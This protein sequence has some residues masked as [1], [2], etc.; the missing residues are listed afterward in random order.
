MNS[1]GT[2]PYSIHVSMLPQTPLP[3]RLPHD[4][5]QSSLCY[6]VGPNCPESV[7]P[8]DC[9]GSPVE[10][11][12]STQVPPGFWWKT[13]HMQE[14]T[15]QGQAGNRSGHHDLTGGSEASKT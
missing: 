6:R 13:T 12:N 7:K 14:E 3:S 2:Q 1:E 11:K 8:L 15:L 9:Q 10:L 5:E 4:I